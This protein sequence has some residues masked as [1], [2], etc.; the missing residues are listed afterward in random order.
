MR[1][2]VNDSDVV[3]AIIGGTLLALAL[4]RP[5]TAWLET[6]TEGH[7]RWRHGLKLAVSFLAFVMGGYAYGSLYSVLHSRLSSQIDSLL[8]GAGI[9]LVIYA[10]I[11]HFEPFVVEARRRG[12][13]SAIALYVCFGSAGVIA[14]GILEDVLLGSHFSSADGGALLGGA[15]IGL[16]GWVLYRVL[17]NPRPHPGAE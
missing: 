2:T 17:S 5:R 16:L 1:G 13:L 12:L 11:V 8:L 10:A 14:G 15:A 3:I 4:T 9:F 7:P 6:V